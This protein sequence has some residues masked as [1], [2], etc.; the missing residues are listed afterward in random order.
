[1]KIKVYAPP[2]AADLSAL[3]DSGY[4]DLEEGATLR[5]VY[6]ALKI[7]FY[8]RRILLCTVNY[9]LTRLSV[10]LDDGD[11]VSFFGMIAGG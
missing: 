5:D 4:L 11:A 2:F 9:R 7:P 3:D 8:L 6:R 10:P 1:M